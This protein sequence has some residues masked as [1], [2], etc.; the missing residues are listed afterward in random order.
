MYGNCGARSPAFERQAQEEGRRIAVRKTKCSCEGLAPHCAGA[1]DEPGSTFPAGE[2]IGYLAL[3]PRLH[4]LA[5]LRGACTFTNRILGYI[6][7][8]AIWQWVVAEVPGATVDVAQ[9]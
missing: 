4:E 1:S 7:A 6:N 9:Y 2:R 3:S 5:Q 8:P